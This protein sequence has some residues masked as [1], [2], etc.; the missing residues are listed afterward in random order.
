VS[1][2]GLAARQGRRSVRRRNA[3]VVFGHCCRVG[4]RRCRWRRGRRRD[5][6][7]VVAGQRH[8]G[9]AHCNANGDR[10]APRPPELPGVSMSAPSVQPVR[11]SEDHD[12]PESVEDP[13]HKAETD[14]GRQHLGTVVERVGRRPLGS[15][16]RSSRATVGSRLTAARPCPSRPSRT[17]SA[18]RRSKR[19]TGARSPARSR[20]RRSSRGARR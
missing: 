15:P 8:Q 16:R 2:C 4:S 12:P 9:R 6:P 11:A 14:G 13:E 3:R 1:L 18:A 7:S 10:D 17:P 19:T 20:C 5:A